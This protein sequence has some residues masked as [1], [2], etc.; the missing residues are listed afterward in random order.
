MAHEHPGKVVDVVGDQ[1][2]SFFPKKAKHA[3]CLSRAGG[4]GGRSFLEQFAR[5]P[6]IYFFSG[7]LLGGNQFSKSE[8]RS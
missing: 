7:Y 4:R 2:H 8:R 6:K 1:E 3:S 5:I